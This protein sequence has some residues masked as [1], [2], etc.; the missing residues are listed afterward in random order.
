MG[1]PAESLGI[2]AHRRQEAY[3]PFF[4]LGLYRVPIADG[5]PEHL[6]D[7]PERRFQEMHLS[8]DGR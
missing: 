4:E 6:C 3:N 1:E 2:R 7:L 8:P 5:A